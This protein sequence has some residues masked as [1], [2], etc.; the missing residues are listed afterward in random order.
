MWHVTLS[1]RLRW[2]V[3]L[4]GLLAACGGG[5]SGG[6]VS[7]NSAGGDT[8]VMR[9]IQPEVLAADEIRIIGN[10]QA[11]PYR[12][13]SPYAAVLADC[14][15][16]DQTN[17]C[18]L[19]TLPLIGYQNSR[20]SV[21]DILDRLVVTHNWMGVRMEQ[22][23][24]RLPA[25]I[26]L[27][28]RPISAILI[29]SEV[30]PSGYFGIRASMQI[31]PIYLWMGLSEKRTLSTESD[32]RT[33]F[34]ADLQ[35]VSLNRF[36]IGN[37][38]AFPFYSLLNDDER[39]FDALVLPFARLLYHELGHANDFIP[40]PQIDQLVLQLTPL[41]AIESLADQSVARRLYDDASLTVQLSALYSL[42][43]VRYRDD[44]PSDNERSLLGDSVGALFGNEGK[45]RFYSF[46]TSRE[47]VATLLATAMMKY[48]FDV[49]LHQGFANKIDDAT[50]SCDYTVEWGVRNRLGA[51][52]VAPRASWVAEQM[53]G[54]SAQRDEAL[55]ANAGAQLPLQTGIDWCSSRFA[56]V[57]LSKQSPQWLPLERQLSDAAI[58]P[59][60]V[61]GHLP[62]NR[63]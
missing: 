48:H 57:V 13:D 28:F 11:R 56:S 37:E 31:D 16:A 43:A 21:D 54:P 46:Y 15:R 6:A 8:D 36:M 27:L 61:P 18:R 2:L 34:G 41:E 30:R 35:F 39:P 9:P 20:P 47:D 5:G 53:L 33:D 26:L 23:L 58:V 14:A 50:S 45:P 4:T 1:W 22:L 44:P 59:R 3:L 60:H 55:A 42:A 12:S 25:D 10:D 7:D 51:A 63:H 17:A 24:E 62:A 49:E 52:M 40:A 19:D 38:Y 29:G 32:F